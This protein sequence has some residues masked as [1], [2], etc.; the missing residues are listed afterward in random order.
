ML[1]LDVSKETLACALLDP[2]TRTACW[3]ASVPNTPAAVA[4]LLARVPPECAWVMEPTGRYSLSVAR[5]AMAA[6]RTVLLAPPRK[7]KAFLASLQSRAKTDRL[8]ARGLGRYALCAPLSPYPVKSEAVERLTQLLVA[9]RGLSQAL[10]SLKQRLPELPY[11]AAPLKAAVADRRRQLREL[12]RQ[13]EA[14]RTHLPLSRRLEQVHGIGPVTATAV[15]A[16]LMSKH[17]PHPDQFVAHLGL[18]VAVRQLGK[19]KGEVGLT[20]QGDAELRR[21]LYLCAKSSGR[22]K[23]SPFLA[24]YE[25]EQQKGLAKTAALC[26]VARKMAKLCWSLARHPEA[27]YDPT[28]VYSQN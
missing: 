2:A 27:V 20:R 21:L 10:S 14:E 15:A 5:Q 17:F 13:I 11:A 16:C 12:D 22:A 8:D 18:D 19:R 24:Q 26:A 3:E 28:R 4:E 1:S 7:A 6:G 23:G 25:R 9:R